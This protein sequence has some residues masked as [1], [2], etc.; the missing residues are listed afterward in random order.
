MID[1]IID[2]LSDGSQSLVNPLLKTKVLATRLGNDELLNWVD[3]ELNGY[4]GIDRSDIP[5]YRIAKAQ[6]SCTI[7]DQN[8]NVT[9]NTPFPFTLIGEK[10]A[11]M[12]FLEFPLSDG[13]SALERL[14]K[15]PKGDSV[16]REFPIDFSAYISSEIQKNGARIQVSNVRVTT[17]LS[18]IT[19]TLSEIRNRF[20][21]LMLSLE[22][23]F[24]D[25][26]SISGKTQEQKNQI[27]NHITI[28]MEQNNIKNSGDGSAINTGNKNTINSASGKNINQVNILDKENKKNLVQ[29][30]KQIKE[31]IFSEEF[32]EKE[33][34]EFEIERIEKQLQ[35]V[36]PNKT[37]VKQ[38]LETLQSFFTSIAANAWTNPVLIGIQ[39]MLNSIG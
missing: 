26:D 28:I 19:Q 33:D 27:S 21:D 35:K 37:I 39:N 36:E 29:L 2:E 9:Y 22:A 1:K 3:S 31:A 11:Q 12:L 30:V 25:L 8:G 24:P 32:D 20:L 18:S 10:A 14:E 13:V 38:S 4:N 5:D 23:T 16:G 15:N 7:Q 17:Q 6:S 34:A